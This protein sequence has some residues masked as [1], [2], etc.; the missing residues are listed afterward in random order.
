MKAAKGK[1]TALLAEA[2]RLRRAAARLRSI[3]SGPGAKA[4]AAR[5]ERQA[6]ELAKEGQVVNPDE[7]RPAC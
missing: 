7:R 3:S 2:E 6:G 1:T 4:A 5:L